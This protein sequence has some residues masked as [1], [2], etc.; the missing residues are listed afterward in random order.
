MRV[1]EKE[2]DGEKFSLSFKREKVRE[3]QKRQQQQKK[4][5]TQALELVEEARD[6]RPGPRAVDADHKHEDYAEADGLIFFV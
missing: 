2:N 6:H 3:R 4:E 5:L 1:F